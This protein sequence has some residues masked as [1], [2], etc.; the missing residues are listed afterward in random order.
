VHCLCR[1]GGSAGAR[2][3][4]AGAGARGL[5]ARTR[6]TLESRTSSEEAN[7]KLPCRATEAAASHEGCTRY[8]ALLAVF[9]NSAISRRRR[10]PARA[11]GVHVGLRQV[12]EVEPVRNEQLDRCL[13]RTIYHPPLRLKAHK[14]EL[15][16]VPR[17]ETVAEHKLSS[18]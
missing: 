9:R 7:V 3:E 15:K 14:K 16:Q 2:I 5:H 17:L 1:A 4:Q 18:C 8:P 11:P 6:P 10:G 12:F 13:M